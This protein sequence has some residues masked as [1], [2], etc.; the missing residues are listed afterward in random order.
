MSP[1]V[2]IGAS[3]VARL[4]CASLTQRHFDVVHLDAPDDPEL[5]QITQHDP[6]GVAVVTHDDAVAVRYALAIAH[7]SPHTPMVVTVFDRTI[8][9]QLTRLIPHCQV[10]SPADLATPSLAGPCIAATID[11]AHTAPDGTTRVLRQSAHGD[12]PTWQPLP[13][14][15]TSRIRRRFVH[16][17]GTLRSHDAGTR[18]LLT[19]LIGLLAILLIDWIWLTVGKG[20]HWVESLKEAVQVVATVG[21]APA[22]HGDHT[23]DVFAALAMLAAIVF[24]AMFTAGIIERLLGT[25]LIGLIGQRVLPRRNHVIVVGLGQVGLRLCLELRKLGIPVVAIERDDRA[26]NLRLARALNIPTIVGHGTDRTLLERARLDRARCLAAVGSDD[27]DNIA[28]SVAAHGVHPDARL[29]LRAGEHEALTD[30]GS[31]LALG[32]T[33]NVATLS[34]TFVVARL[35]G[36]DAHR[37]V[38]AN[39]TIHLELD[40]SFEQFVLAA[41]HHCPHVTGTD[42][43]YPSFEV[44]LRRAPSRQRTSTWHESGADRQ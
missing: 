12:Q 28:V 39:D 34:A 29:V 21:P 38:V 2:V 20:H 31:L 19:G 1:F 42:A 33:R 3:N 17:V 22:S 37:V 25:S 16:S 8:A 35:L 23:Y 26:R 11:A 44:R 18:M 43:H 15:R 7:I 9:N 13:H 6:A 5:L 36:L 32:I 4:V 14:S 40:G 27:R 41:R 10:T 30:T 24:T